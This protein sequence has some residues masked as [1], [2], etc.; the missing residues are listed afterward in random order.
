MAAVS[1]AMTT[2]SESNAD[3]T[4]TEKKD[5]AAVA[6]DNVVETSRDEGDPKALSGK[7]REKAI[8]GRKG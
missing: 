4:H 7:V 2:T 6:K 5:S 8:E 3:K 1:S